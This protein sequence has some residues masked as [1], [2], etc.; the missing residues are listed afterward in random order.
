MSITVTIGKSEFT[1]RRLGHHSAA[2]TNR[3]SGVR[4]DVRA[5][6]AWAAQSAERPTLDVSSGHELTVWEI[7]PRVGL[8]ADSPSLCPSTA[9]LRARALSLEINKH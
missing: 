9:L 6:G 5:R 7:E 2:T 3:C 1:E 8:C 4:H